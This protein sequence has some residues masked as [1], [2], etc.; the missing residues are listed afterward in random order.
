MDWAIFVPPFSLHGPEIRPRRQWGPTPR[1]TEI[2]IVTRWEICPIN[3]EHLHDDYDLLW[4][5]FASSS[6]KVLMARPGSVGMRNEKVTLA[7]WER[8]KI[9]TKQP[10]DKYDR[11][12]K[13]TYEQKA[14]AY[15]SLWDD[16]IISL[17]AI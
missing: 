5:V 17:E 1:E 4:Q 9:V 16:W 13:Q 11:L 7:D 3:N 14:W 12:E 6:P 8:S 15:E 2:R 10:S